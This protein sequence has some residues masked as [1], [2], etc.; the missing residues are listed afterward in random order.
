[1]KWFAKTLI[2][3]TLNLII[4]STILA[5]E[6]TRTIH[7]FVALCDN[8]TQWIRPVPERLGDGDDPKN[9]LY[10][11]AKYGVKTCFVRSKNWTLIKTQ[12]QVNEHIL[13]RVIFE[14]KNKHTYLIADAYRGKHI[15][16]AIDDVLRSS[17]GLYEIQVH[18]EQYGRLA[19]GYH[20]DLLVYVGHNA[21]ID[22]WVPTILYKRLF[23]AYPKSIEPGRLH[24]VVILACKSKE[25]FAIP[26]QQS[27]SYPLLWTNT[28]LAPEAYT[29]EAALEGW[30][31]D[32]TGD[33]LI[34]RAATAYSTYQNCSFRAAKTIFAS[35]W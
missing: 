30:L 7:V 23:N 32:E 13:E 15:E 17:A 9:N 1:M 5:H 27:K 10:W 3:I 19:G 21:L 2:I 20:A 4:Q 25:Y 11:G 14:H 34:Q 24:N 29:L 28:K 8:K 12:S 6:H 33:Q 35:G 31:K 18:T 22:V 26:L 16:D